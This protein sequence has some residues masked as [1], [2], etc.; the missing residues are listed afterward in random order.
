MSKY[1]NI[2]AFIVSFAIGILMVYL[3]EE[4]K[5]VIYVYPTPETV[6]LLQYKDSTGAC[7]HF[8]QTQVKCPADDKI[9]KMPAQA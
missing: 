6:D 1:I 9:S 8:K 5:R 2:P 4:D 7:F 3:F